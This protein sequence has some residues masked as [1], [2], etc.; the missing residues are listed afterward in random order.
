MPTECAPCQLSFAS[1]GVFD[2]HLAW[3]PGDEL[4]HVH[5]LRVGGLKQ[6]EDGTWAWA[7]NA[8]SKAPGAGAI[9]GA[10]RDERRTCVVVMT[11]ATSREEIRLCDPECRDQFLIDLGLKG[12]GG[13]W[14]FRS[15]GQADVT[16][17]WSGTEYHVTWE[18]RR[19]SS[20]PCAQCEQAWR[21]RPARVLPP[22]SEAQLAA[23]ERFIAAR[24]V[25]P[26]RRNAPAEVHGGAQSPGQGPGVVQDTPQAEDGSQ[27]DGD[28]EDIAI[29]ATGR[30]FMARR[31]GWLTRG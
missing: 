16:V 24:P 12:S 1:P 8:G 22:P 30:G 20:I 31:P 21:F 14:A 19:P 15:R 28:D 29:V 25:P 9:S 27:R 2:A 11:S 10:V 5:P 17:P 7:T 13:G 26:N 4:V 3:P 6:L 18:R 23:R